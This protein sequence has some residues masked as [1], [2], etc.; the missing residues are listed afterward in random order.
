MPPKKGKAAG[1]GKK[2]KEA[3][4]AAA[5]LARVTQLK[6]LRTAYAA[7]C[8]FFVAEP[9]PS[10]VKRIETELKSADGP[11]DIDKLILSQMSLNP[12]D[13][14]SLTT[15]MNA[16]SALTG[17]Y[18]WRAK[19]D[20]KGLEALANFLT[21]HPTVATLHLMDCQITAVAAKHVQTICRSSTGLKSLLMDHNPLGAEGIGV[22]FAGIQDN[23]ATVLQRGSFR[24][25]EATP[26]AAD[27]IGCALAV[28]ATITELQ[29][30]GNFL[31]DAGLGLL[32][33]HMR[34]NA[35]LQS[36]YLAANQI[37]NRNP[38]PASSLVAPGSTSSLP[39]QPSSSHN[40]RMVG[41]GGGGGGGGAAA[42][43][44]FAAPLSTFSAATATPLGTSQVSMTTPTGSSGATP[45]SR[46]CATVA[47]DAPTLTFLDLRGNHVGDAGAELILEMLKSR[48][49]L[50]A[51]KQ[52]EGL[53]VWV[54][55]RMSEDLFEKIWELNDAMA[56]SGAKKGGKGGKK[57]KK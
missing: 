5:A 38:P 24:Y 35:T 10:L 55:E 9:L 26:A 49:A 46:F 25:C 4:A 13:V 1:G 44:P 36:L 2:A 19:V 57:G 27:S 31:G 16:Y 30:D 23:P 39:F 42:S 15:T 20:I 6:E 11:E 50:L 53:V 28:N 47:T 48:K 29:L 52:A 12:G 51:A 18:I 33:R 3:E 8:K 22:I 56:G 32:S 17:I 54:T 14:Y 34:S 40:G 21:S 37:S 7:Q 41:G 45:L 43:D